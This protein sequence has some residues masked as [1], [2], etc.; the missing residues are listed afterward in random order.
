MGAPYLEDPQTKPNMSKSSAHLG[1]V[2]HCG[3]PRGAPE[4][5][6]ACILPKLVSMG[7]VGRQWG[8]L[9]CHKSLNNRDVDGIVLLSLV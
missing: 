5:P 8:E 9:L 6:C 7:H 1:A 4:H 2:V 3:A